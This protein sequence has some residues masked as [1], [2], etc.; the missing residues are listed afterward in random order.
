MTQVNT[1]LMIPGNDQV[2]VKMGVIKTRQ[3]FEH[4]ISHQAGHRR[5]N[6]RMSLG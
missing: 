1:D 2:V 6:T 5:N 4:P 3:S